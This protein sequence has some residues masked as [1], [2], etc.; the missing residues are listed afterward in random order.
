MYA[1][2]TTNSNY[3]FSYD[4]GKVSKNLKVHDFKAPGN[5]TRHPNVI[6]PHEV[7]DI[8]Q[9]VDTKDL[10]QDKL[11]EIYAYYSLLIDMHIAQVR[12]GIIDEVS[13]VPPH[14]NQRAT[15]FASEPMLDNMFFEHYHRWREP[16]RELLDVEIRWQ[17]AL[18]N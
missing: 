3:Y 18:K 9:Y 15:S 11:F 13:Y 7:C 1:E 2:V 5:N 6:L 8:Q 17:E 12:P 10:T 4:A 14:M 16:T